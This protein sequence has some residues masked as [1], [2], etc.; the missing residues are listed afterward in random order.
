MCAAG[1]IRV[2]T[3]ERDPVEHAVEGAQRAEISAEETI[4]P[5]APEK[6]QKRDGEFHEEK[7]P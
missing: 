7:R 6:R 3:V 2:E 5:H 1:L 4:D